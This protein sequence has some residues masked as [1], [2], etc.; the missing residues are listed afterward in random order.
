MA[1]LIWLVVTGF[2]LRLSFEPSP[3]TASAGC[4]WNFL[5]LPMLIL[6]SLPVIGLIVWG[7]WLANDADAWDRVGDLFDWD[8]AL[9]TTWAAPWVTIWLIQLPLA[10]LA[11]LSLGFVR[12]LGKWGS[13]LL[14]LPAFALASLPSEALLL[15]WFRMARTEE[16]LDDP[17]QVLVLPWMMGGISLLIFK[18]FFD[19]AA[20]KYNAARQ[21]GESAGEA[22]F[23]KVFLPSIPIS[24]LIGFVLSFISA[25]SLLWALVS[26]RSPENLTLPVQ[27]VVLRSGFALES[28]T[29]AGTAV[30]YA[31]ILAAIFFPIFALLQLLVVDRLAILAGGGA[32]TAAIPQPQ[33]APFQMPQQPIWTASTPEPSQPVAP[34]AAEPT[35][36][37]DVMGENEFDFRI[38]SDDDAN[39]L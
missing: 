39:K 30:L 24:L 25:Q 11:G 7:V 18:L 23:R 14:F 10:Y 4:L 1:F 32:V 15:E 17:N 21:S 13:S 5:S 38:G 3:A 37:E 19:G 20:D 8:T 33:A 16:W 31:G 34:P 9:G 2:R 27:M 12:P 35:P 29:L 22:F 36:S 28:S 26:L 6:W